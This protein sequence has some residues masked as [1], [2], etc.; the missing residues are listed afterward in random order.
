MEKN[1]KQN[2]C[3]TRLLKL[4]LITVHQV[5]PTHPLLNVKELFICRCDRMIKT[6]QLF[7]ACSAMISFPP[8]SSAFL[9]YI[10]NAVD[11]WSADYSDMASSY[12]PL[13]ISQYIIGEVLKVFVIEWKQIFREHVL[14]H[15]VRTVFAK[16]HCQRTRV[17][18]YQ[19]LASIGL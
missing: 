7:F 18:N 17:Y 5:S 2:L 6:F 11:S 10:L 12:I 1:V 9:T 13:T 8:V 16:F 14:V 19:L 4:Y 15:Y 3:S